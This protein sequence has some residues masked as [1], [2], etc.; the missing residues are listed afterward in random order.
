MNRIRSIQDETGDADTCWG[1]GVCVCVCVWRAGCQ[2]SYFP[3]KACSSERG[4][5]VGHCFSS[6]LG[7]DAPAAEN[8]DPSSP[9]VIATQPSYETITAKLCRLYGTLYCFLFL[10]SCREKQQISIS[11][12]PQENE[13]QGPH[14]VIHSK[15][16]TSWGPRQ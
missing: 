13:I 2:G 1:V 4:D 14:V 12:W 9:C 5:E 7:Q 3:S 15:P 10:S 8:L 16:I 11:S 6:G